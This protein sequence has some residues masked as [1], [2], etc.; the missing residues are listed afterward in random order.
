MQ[1]IEG[2]TDDELEAK[3]FRLEPC[4]SKN[5]PM[6]N[7]QHVYRELR[8]KGVHVTLMTLWEEYQSDHADRPDDIYEYSWFC[9]NYAAWAKLVEPIM[10]QRHVYGEKFFVDYAGDTVAIVDA[11]TGEVRLAQIF[12]AA[13]GGSNYTFAEATW[14]Q[15][16]PCWIASHV[17]MF[18][19]YGGCCKILV[20]DNLKSGVTKA[21]FY[22]PDLNPTY[23]EMAMYYGVAVIPARKAEPTDKAKVEST[24]L[25]V[26]RWI[27]AKLR[28]HTF[29][30]LDQLNEAIAELL[31][32]L[33][34]RPFQKLSGNRR[35][36]FETHELPVLG[37][38]PA[39][40]YEYAD[41][42][43]PRVHIDY[44]V[45][46]FESYYSVPHELIGK[47]VDARV[48]SSVV[49]IFNGGV[50]VASHK[51]SFM[52]GSATTLVEHMPAH[53]QA[54]ASWT[55]ERMCSWAAKVGTHA[56]EFVVGLMTRKEHPEQG[57]RAALG[58]LSLAK[59]YSNERLNAA[60][61]RAIHYGSYKVRTLRNILENNLETQS[62]ETSKSKTLGHHENV[63]GS[64]YW[65]ETGDLPNQGLLFPPQPGCPE[66]GKTVATT[67]KESQVA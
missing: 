28:N 11:T 30:S 51:R 59:K 43:R 14:S 41:C 24:V 64:S 4:A 25:V 18:K 67:I 26:E 7:W 15:E 60:C 19:F 58:T 45:Q 31:I 57:V 29:Y 36:M 2:M 5:R 63:R 46:L 13:A 44:H 49:E 23:H 20:P 62:L 53:H 21:D 17:R 12:V 10:R 50:R 1:L 37:A 6:P 35:E 52:K 34:N 66:P 27:L 55:P 33:N 48:T 61:R 39:I 38:L 8:R 47:R 65:S 56:E 54:V 16:L 32:E 40:P 9:Q 3:L 42:K 22:E